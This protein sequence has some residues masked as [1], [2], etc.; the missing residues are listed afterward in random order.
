MSNM[1]RIFRDDVRLATGSVVAMLVVVGLCLVP[2]LFAGFAIAGSWN[3]HASTGQLKVAVANGDEG[4]ESSLVAT[5]L[6]IGDRVVNMLHGNDD[7]D[8]TFVDEDEALDGVRSGVYYAAIVIPVDFSAK[9]M[10]VLSSDAEQASVDYYLNMKENPLAPVIAGE[11]EAELMKDIRVKFTEAVDEVAVGLV[12]DLVTFANGDNAKDFG[13]RLVSRLDEVAKGLDAAAA[14]VRA[15]SN[16]SSAASS[17][18]TA[19]AQALA[20]SEDTADA[21]SGVIAKSSEALGAAIESAQSA[22]GDIER[23]VNAA[24]SDSG[25]DKVGTGTAQQLVKDVTALDSSVQSVVR[26][27]DATADELKKTVEGLA[28]STDSAVSDLDGIRD[29]LGLAANRLSASASKIRKFQ[30]DIASAIAKG[31]LNAVASI[32]SGNAASIAQWLAEP[33]SIGKHAVYPVENYGS[34][35]AP[36]FTVLSLW[37]GA[38]ILVVLMK[39]DVPATRLDRYEGETGQPVKPYERYL[40]RYFVFLAI[41]LLQATVVTLVN[42]LFLRIQCA[43]PLLF[44]AVCWVCAIAFSSIAYALTVSFGRVGTAL[45][46]LLLVMLVAGSGGDYP[47]QM[48]GDAFQVLYPLLPFAHA[49]HAMQASIAGLYGMEYVFDLLLVAAFLIPSLLLGLALRKPIM[50]AAAAFESKVQDTDLM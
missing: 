36:F 43:N 33:V 25:I 15:F 10:S 18:A 21:S 11:G 24:K 9:M 46:A 8:W 20:G 22:A 35:Q 1:G 2:A 44:L 32:V 13:T 50:R 26:Q 16:L 30:D 31:N 42:V 37:L 40:G 47:I 6:N 14:Q 38:I 49:L 27:A 48:M 39:V 3:P 28:G 34:S 45:C 7:Y 19:S 23:Q 12:S 4:Y 5:E 29:S 17:L 41:S